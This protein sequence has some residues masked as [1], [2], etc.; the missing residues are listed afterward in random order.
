MAEDNESQNTV[1]SPSEAIGLERIQQYQQ[2]DEQRQDEDDHPDQEDGHI[3]PKREPI[4]AREFVQS[5]SEDG[6]MEQSRLTKEDKPRNRV[7]SD[8]K[9]TTSNKK[10]PEPK[11]AAGGGPSISK[12]KL[13][14]EAG[15]GN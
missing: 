14:E 7:I 13:L 15:E 11:S 9:V 4:E 3:K 10:V 12:N 2:G 8:S 6:R 5:S 1:P